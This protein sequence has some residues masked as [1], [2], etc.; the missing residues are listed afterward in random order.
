MKGRQRNT[1]PKWQMARVDREKVKGPGTA[2]HETGGRLEAR[3]ASNIEVPEG[4]GGVDQ[5]ERGRK[6]SLE[7]EQKGS[8]E[9]EGKAMQ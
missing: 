9:G 6:G 1:R 2:K 3:S 8:L 7:G 5:P 4:H